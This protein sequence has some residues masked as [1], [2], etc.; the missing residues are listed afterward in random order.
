MRK[1][2]LI[3]IL[4]GFMFGLPASAVAKVYDISP[5]QTFKWSVSQ[6][7][8]GDTLKLTDGVYSDSAVFRVSGT[9][10]EPI[11][12]EG[13]KNTVIN[14]SRLGEYV[15]VFQTK[16]Q[17]Y[18]V[19]KDLKFEKVRAGVQV[20]DGS[21]HIVIDGLRADQ[22]HFA[23]KISDGSHVTVRNSYADNSRNAF[24]GEGDT[25]DIS[26]ENVEAYRSKDIYK[27]HDPNFLNGDGF[28]FENKTYNLRFKNIKSMEHWDAGLDIKGSHV[29]IEDVEVSGCKN[30]LKLWGE[31]IEA[32][33]VL[34][35]DNR[36]QTK[37]D[38]TT[39]DGNGIHIAAGATRILRST[40]RD[41]DACEIKLKK[42]A[43]LHIEDSTISRRTQSGK[44]VVKQ[45]GAQLTEKNVTWSQD[46][47]SA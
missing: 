16:G 19:F 38:G 33:N 45:E 37:P 21:H 30:G 14:G 2:L 18:L 28:V 6:L 20:D 39:V 41:N 29:V 22:C 5:K 10:N 8:P 47:I 11:T 34:S 35:H 25:H 36:S 42:E 43:K 44:L 4:I 31:D 3:V 9:E 32:R 1:Y 15:P 24:R 46:G 17:S 12:I 27:G 13:S 23:V 7:K 40:I 26:F